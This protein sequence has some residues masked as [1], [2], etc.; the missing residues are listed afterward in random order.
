MQDGQPAEAGAKQWKGVEDSGLKGELLPLNPVAQS[1]QPLPEPL[2]GGSGGRSPR[3]ARLGG[4]GSEQRFGVQLSPAPSAVAA[5]G[6][7]SPAS[8]RR[9][10]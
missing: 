6:V 1:D 3:L 4:Q 2:P 9:A 10:A 8:S 5:S 7:I